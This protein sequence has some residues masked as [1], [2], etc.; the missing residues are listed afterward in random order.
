MQAEVQPQWRVV[1]ETIYN[2]RHP[3]TLAY[4]WGVTPAFWGTFYWAD[5]DNGPISVMVDPSNT[6]CIINTV[7]T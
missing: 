6:P 1:C 4:V 3:D 5:T 7:S 2:I